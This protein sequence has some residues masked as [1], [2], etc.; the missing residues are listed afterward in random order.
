MI[1]APIPVA[2]ASTSRW[3][4]VIAALLAPLLVALHVPGAFL[5]DP[6]APMDLIFAH[7]PWA[8]VK[9]EDLIPGSYV[10]SDQF[11]YLHPSYAY[12]VESLRAG[13]LPAYTS[14]S[15][16]GLPYYFA[17]TNYAPNHVAIGLGLLFGAGPGYTVYKLLLVT[18]AALAMFGFLTRKG[19]H[20]LAALWAAALVCISSTTLTALGIPM[21]DQ[22]FFAVIS[23]WA[24]DRLIDRPMAI[25]AALL[26]VAVYF[27]LVSGY[28]PGTVTLLFFLTLYALSALSASWRSKALVPGHV[29]WLGAAGLGCLLLAMPF[30][31]EAF[32]QFLSK[33]GIGIES[34]S[35][36][37]P[38]WAFKPLSFA[39]GFAPSM[40][41][42]G[43][44]S[45]GPGG[46]QWFYDQNYLG[47]ASIVLVGL[48]VGAIGRRTGAVF[49]LVMLSF[50]TLTVFNLFGFNERGLGSLPVFSAV[51]AYTHMY[52]W[53]LCLVVVS[54]YGAD[55]ILSRLQSARVTAWLT[56]VSVAMPV[57]ILLV[58]IRGN[59]EL[60]EMLVDEL[61]RLFRLQIV[62]V[63]IV[64][65]V[66][67]LRFA[68]ISEERRRGFVLAGFSA[69]LAV[70]VSDLLLVNEGANRTTPKESYFPATAATDFLRA[71]QGDGKILPLDNSLLAAAH[72]PYGIRSLGY[73][74]FFKPR[75]RR[76]YSAFSPSLPLDGITTQ[77]LF[78]VE[79][80]LELD[81]P[82]LQL[83]GVKYVT[84]LPHK[85]LPTPDRTRHLLPRN[86][87]AQFAVA[88]GE[89]VTQYIH[90]PDALS[91]N[92]VSLLFDSVPEGA[93]FDL[94]IGRQAA[95]AE[96]IVPVRT[97]SMS[98]SDLRPDI[99]GRLQW[100]ARLDDTL[101]LA[102][103]DQFTLTLRNGEVP[104]T[105]ATYSERHARD[106]LQREGENPKI[107]SWATDLYSVETGSGNRPAPDYR[108]VF[109]DGVNIYE[110]VDFDGRAFVPSQC[111]EADGDEAF[112]IIQTELPDL[113]RTV[114]RP[115]CPAGQGMGS[116]AILREG[117]GEMTLRAD[118]S[119]PGTVVVGDN[120]DPRWVARAGGETLPVSR[121]NYNFFAI[122]VPAGVTEIDFRYAPRGRGLL[123]GLALLGWAL[124]LIYLVFTAV[125]HLRVRSRGRYL[126]PSA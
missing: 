118:M 83:M 103:T 123:F 35:T 11:D 125:R 117:E 20:P 56:A 109:Q 66:V 99:S 102:P 91:V 100:W 59:E 54:A 28:P 7:P 1:A 112:N 25:R 75:V 72:L 26:C 23:L 40:L 51:R 86:P 84:T 80:G 9:P 79:K 16:N 67:G 68:P 113:R 124:L 36:G 64:L 17:M 34:R 97:L 24:L 122:D 6:I 110:N 50:L 77:H 78:S 101:V 96:E 30:L 52:S 44:G 87:K 104:I 29:G 41:G 63:L 94:T 39:L 10:P 2:P 47:L 55:V 60:A 42:D 53:L 76:T 48:G 116:V 71:N 121:A 57:V 15:G 14:L 5:L 105:L 106:W 33:E 3:W 27:L 119:A 81:D 22:F 90:S 69:A 114:L 82:L 58:L 126:Q 85:S 19:L 32:D 13:D 98:T 61:P 88:A 12:I 89:T 18:L 111:R 8:S 108:L 93:T 37:Y 73:R 120:Y 107:M 4:W 92:A 65:A 95:D 43:L 45:A 21:S 49:F 115:D 70:T 62:P 46:T 38:G 31:A 74:G